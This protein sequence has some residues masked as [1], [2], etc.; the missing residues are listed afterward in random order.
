[1]STTWLIIV[2]LLCVII[3]L[4]IIRFG[5]SV[6]SKKQKTNEKKVTANVISP[7]TRLFL[8]FFAIINWNTEMQL[9]LANIGSLNRFMHQNLLILMQTPEFIF[10][11]PLQKMVSFQKEVLDLFLETSASQW[12][13][14]KP[15]ALLKLEDELNIKS[16]KE[17]YQTIFD[18]EKN[19]LDQSWTMQNLHH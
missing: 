8:K 1:M 7:E 14:K 10:T 15:F 6:W 16:L 11:L 17:D 18:S 5:F 9:K 4:T 13:T 3:G 19:R 2:L 12:E